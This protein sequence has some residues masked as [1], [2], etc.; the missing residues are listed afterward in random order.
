MKVRNAG[1]EN[2]DEK[3]HVRPFDLCSDLEFPQ[4]LKPTASSQAFSATLLDVDELV[5][6]TCIEAFLG[7]LNNDGNQ[8][9]PK[10]M[11]QELQSSFVSTVIEA[12]NITKCSED[13]LAGI[14]NPWGN[15]VCHANALA[16]WSVSD[17]SFSWKSD[18]WFDE[19]R[20]L[21]RQAK[22][23]LICSTMMPLG[24]N[25][26]GR[27]GDKEYLYVCSFS[28]CHGDDKSNSDPAGHFY[29]ISCP[30]HVRPLRL[31]SIVQTAGHLPW[32]LDQKHVL[33]L[34]T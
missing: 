22:N 5:P 3:K 31:A 21:E 2:N 33:P 24:E 29:V 11:T 16:V 32:T 13:E 23:L 14:R 1:G 19:H 34:P 12:L 9:T 8:D 30:P 7:L 6:N 25:S 4:L 17:H 27:I 10:S 28:W 20:K 26:H 15:R 18:G